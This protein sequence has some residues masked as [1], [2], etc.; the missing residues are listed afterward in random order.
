MYR[1]KIEER[2]NGEKRYIPQKG[3][4]RISGRWIKRQEIRWD[5][6][7]AGSFSSESLALE[8]VNEYKKLDEQRKGEEV[9][10][11]TYKTID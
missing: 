8:K 7:F 4:L 6:I 10:S 3:Y 1:I 2:N 11:T 5:S 9:K